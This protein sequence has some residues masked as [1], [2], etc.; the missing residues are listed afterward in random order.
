MHDSRLR[1]IA[2]VSIFAALGIGLG[3]L[4]GRASDA[5]WWQILPWVL[6]AGFWA[7]LLVRHRRRPDGREV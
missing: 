5:L 3:V 6:L 2:R 7:Y 4:L 1:L